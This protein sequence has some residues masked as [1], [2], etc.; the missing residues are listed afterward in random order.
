MPSAK[1]EKAKEGAPMKSRREYVVGS[2]DKDDL[3]FYFLESD[4]EIMS[5]EGAR[6]F[7]KKHGHKY[8]DGIFGIYRLVK[9]PLKRGKGRK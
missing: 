2:F 1:D 3:R 7:L 4:N 9:I 6:R 8:T 5:L